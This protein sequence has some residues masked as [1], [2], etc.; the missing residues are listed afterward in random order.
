MSQRFLRCPHCGLPHAIDDVACGVTGRPLE[1]RKGAR[2]AP[3]PAP[4]PA[5][6]VGRLQV[7]MPVAIP[8]SKH[9]S[10]QRLSPPSAPA[11]PAQKSL[12]PF[13]TGPP[14]PDSSILGQTLGGKY[15]A[16]RVLGEGGMGTVYECEHIQLHRKVAVKV[17]HPAQ[18][19]KKA[20]VQRFHHEAQVA[21]AIGH[22]NICEIY[23]IGE[24]DGG[25]PF[26]VME[27]LTGETL[28][29][30]IASEGALP[31]DDL[32]EVISQVLSGLIAAHD[33][34]IIH[35]DIKPENIFLSSRPGI[36]P[37]A[38]ILDFGISKVAGAD[39]LH[40]TRTGMVMGTPF[41]MSPEQA[42]GD[43][44]LDHR[45]DIYA[46]GV[47][48]YEC[49]TG[50]RPFTAANYNA[51]LVQILTTNAR[52]PHEIRP[53][54]PEAFEEFVAKAMHRERD[55][56]YANTIE[57]QRA[58]VQ[59]RDPA[60]IQQRRIA[61]IPPEP[62]P[63]VTTKRAGDPTP[64]RK[65][66]EPVEARRELELPA[67]SVNIEGHDLLD[68]GQQNVADSVEVPVA[69]E[70]RRDERRHLA[71]P[72]ARPAPQPAQKPVEARRPAPAAPPIERRAAPAPP[73]IPR[74]AATAPLRSPSV[75]PA[76]PRAGIPARVINPRAPIPPRP[77]AT[78]PTSAN[79]PSIPPPLPSQRKARMITPTPT[80]VDPRLL[81]AFAARQNAPPALDAPWLNDG[82]DPTEIGEIPRHEPSDVTPYP[83]EGR[84]IDPDSTERID[85][86]RLGKLGRRPRAALR[87]PGLP[88]P[89]RELGGVRAP[90]PEQLHRPAEEPSHADRWEDEAPT[91]LFDRKQ[92]K[93]TPGGGAVRASTTE[94]APAPTGLGR[95][96]APDEP[97]PPAIPRAPR[98]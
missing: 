42:R 70:P 6:S 39:D 13:D 14:P 3:M 78:A 97:R 12:A 29:D 25:A 16:I 22:P 26:L 92:L 89:R 53:A 86:P 18:V 27:L 44:T 55:K 19:R 57:M 38:K 68:S 41:Y 32:V 45:V 52:P 31:F 58:L 15:R 37:L 64:P 81:H 95:T 43:R 59:L 46:T 8:V 98:R 36:G 82:D 75:P 21:G 73:P 88:E 90:T 20:S 76:A 96:P 7:A 72:V 34:G 50:R 84:R 60:A 56:R 74:P 48:T 51:L 5:E 66:N 62:V 80:P 23:D 87:E 83:T 35:R 47:M 24:G 49:L 93:S 54:V 61:S 10:Q 69:V 65:M 1:P 4:S 33:K 11:I 71:Q 28:A 67:V 91:T 17:L 40:L 2:V 63:L 77:V 9:P 30:R 79:R 94:R 85:P